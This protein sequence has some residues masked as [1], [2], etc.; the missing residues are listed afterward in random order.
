MRLAF[1]GK[2]GSGKSTVAG[3]V[4]RILARGRQPVL[5]VDVDPVPG[6]AYTLGLGHVPEAGLPAELAERREGKGWVMK[7]AVSAGE[8]V[9]RYAVIGPDD[10]RFLQ[11][12]KMPRHV[13]PGSTVA[14]RH[15]IESFYRP[16]W[17]VVGDLSAGTRQ[18]FFGWASFATRIVI[19]SE[20][21][22]AGFLTARRLK[23]L[24][25]TMPEA[26]IGL[27]LN[28]TDGE[29]GTREAARELDLPV[30]SI[31]PYDEEIVKAERKGLAPIDAAPHSGA[32]NAI[33][34]FVEAMMALG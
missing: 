28:K 7:E 19:V 5:A 16:G 18:A 22:P 23:R 17:S 30:W 29:G 13:H 8:L 3:T 15:I 11:L 26:A 27:V 24:A 12:G 33:E 21:T 34:R 25:E 20:P 32:V 6:L 2:G 4:A 1:I 14:F 9:D 31:L 10:V